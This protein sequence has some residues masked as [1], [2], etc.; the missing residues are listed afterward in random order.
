MVSIILADGRKLVFR[1]D[2]KLFVIRATQDKDKKHTDLDGPPAI[3][4]MQPAKF[5]H[6][7]E[8]IVLEHPFE[9]ALVEFA[10]DWKADTAKKRAKK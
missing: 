10:T 7:D 1:D 2:E 8:Y 4:K 3:A 5:I 9:I 6:A